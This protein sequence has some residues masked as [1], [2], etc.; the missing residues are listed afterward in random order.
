MWQYRVFFFNL[1][2]KNT[3][4]L[5]S[6]SINTI[7]TAVNCYSKKE[8]YAEAELLDEPS[9]NGRYLEIIAK[10][11]ILQVKV[12]IK[13]CLKS[14]LQVCFFSLK[15]CKCSFS[16]AHLLQPKLHS[17]EKTGVCF[18]TLLYSNFL[19]SLELPISTVQYTGTLECFYQ[20]KSALVRL[21]LNY[22]S[23]HILPLEVMAAAMPH[24]TSETTTAG[25]S[26]LPTPGLY[27]AC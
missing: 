3:L 5:A 18:T 10:I 19:F 25:E 8:E 27:G 21:L 20:N 9:C 6:Q 7:T 26:K 11:T 17:I 14:K 16:N 23:H 13:F 12:K 1:D 2:I 24:G 22:K 4:L 15:D